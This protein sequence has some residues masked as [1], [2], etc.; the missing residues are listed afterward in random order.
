VSEILG[1]PGLVF[2]YG[3]DRLRRL[4]GARFVA[5]FAK[6][7]ARLLLVAAV[8]LTLL[9]AAEA[10]PQRI[11]LAD[12]AAGKL[13]QFQTWIIVSGQL[14]DEPGSTDSDHVYRLTDPEAPNAY[15]V[16]RSPSVQ[17]PG[18]TTVSGRIEGGRDGVPKGYLW[19]ARL[20]ADAQLAAE[21]PPPWTAIALAVIAFT[22]I[23]A[24]RSRYP[25]FVGEPPMDVPPAMHALRVT[26]RGDAAGRAATPAAATLSFGDAEPGAASLSSLGTRRVPVRLHSAFTRVDV[27]RI[28]TLTSS[29]PALRVRSDADDLVLVFASPRERDASFAALQAETQLS[30]QPQASRAT[31]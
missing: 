14:G 2:A 30:R 28:R 25:I 31:G 17:T 3:V 27:G 1:Y 24:R 4:P 12:L 29:Q 21:L 11:S 6:W 22:I 5:P 20:N 8:V 10:S 26:V 9:W 23:L 13:G 7:I 15:L 19:S 18:W 16:V